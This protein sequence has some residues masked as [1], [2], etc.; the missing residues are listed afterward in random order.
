MQNPRGMTLQGPPWGYLSPLQCLKAS[1]SLTPLNVRFTDLSVHLSVTYV[2]HVPLVTP[3]MLRC[4]CVALSP[5]VLGSRDL[6]LCC[7][8][9]GN[10][11][12][13]AGASLGPHPSALLVGAKQEPL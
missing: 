10:A 11:V 13:Q 4:P 6:F 1:L 12:T 5:P 8:V 2:P 9:S 7:C 3:L